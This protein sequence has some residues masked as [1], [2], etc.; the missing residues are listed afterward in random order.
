L[1]I[2][3]ELVSNN[4]LPWMNCTDSDP[5]L[6]QVARI[7]KRCCHTR[8]GIRPSAADVVHF[9]LETMNISSI[10]KSINVLV[11]E[12][13]KERISSQL[14]ANNPAILREEDLQALRKL[15]EY[16]DSMAAFLLGKSIWKGLAS[17]EQ[18]MVPLLCTTE[19]DSKKGKLKLP[20]SLGQ[21]DPYCRNST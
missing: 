6:Q 9:I 7:V 20:V 2:I 14:D 10:P 15:V 17:P 5:L 11:D 12:D 19:E 3:R 16:G 21:A 18:T 4:E 13:V 8:P 1:T